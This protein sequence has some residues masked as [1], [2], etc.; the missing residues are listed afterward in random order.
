MAWHGGMHVQQKSE[1]HNFCY[2]KAQ[3]FVLV[4]QIVYIVSVSNN[5]VSWISSTGCSPNYAG[6]EPE[7]THGK[8]KVIL[9]AVFCALKGKGDP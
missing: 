6:H 3:Y 7:I 5:G 9:N 8:T 1:M 2:Y 4:K